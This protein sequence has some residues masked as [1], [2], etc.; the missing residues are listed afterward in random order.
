MAHHLN[1]AT[2]AR[3]SSRPCGNDLLPSN[4]SIH[5]PKPIHVQEPG[6]VYVR[7][8]ALVD[9]GNLWTLGVRYRFPEFLLRLFLGPSRQDGLPKKLAR[10]EL[11]SSSQTLYAC[12][13]GISMFAYAE[14][15]PIVST[16][17]RRNAVKPLANVLRP[18]TDSPLLFLNK[19][20]HAMQ[21][22]QPRASSC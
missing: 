8:M 15:I 17:M 6:I 12:G 18:T 10:R 19:P 14:G 22:G 4:T 11:P 20:Q 2:T 7:W 9:V 3:D 21:T 13:R 1:P 16:A 5:K